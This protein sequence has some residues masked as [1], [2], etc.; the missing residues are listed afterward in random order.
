MG[1]FFDTGGRWFSADQAGTGAEAQ[2]PAGDGIPVRRKDVDIK[3]AAQRMIFF[4]GDHP[5][6]YSF[7]QAFGAAFFKKQKIPFG[8]CVFLK[9]PEDE[10]GAVPAGFAR[11]PAGMIPRFHSGGTVR[12][13]A[14]GAVKFLERK[15][16]KL[17]PDG[18][19]AFM[20]GVQR[21]G[22]GLYRPDNI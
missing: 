16:R 20:K 4:N 7:C 10:A 8:S 22:K 14:R 11:F 18:A 13:R 3:Q 2:K 6:F 1:S 21:H 9:F 15:R 19:N 17:P 12:Y 5:F